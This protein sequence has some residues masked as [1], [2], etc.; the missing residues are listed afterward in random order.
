MSFAWAKDMNYFTVDVMAL[1]NTRNGKLE[2]A[3]D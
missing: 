2:Q 1:L 3:C